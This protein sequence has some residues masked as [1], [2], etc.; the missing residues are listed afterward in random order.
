MDIKIKHKVL[1]SLILCCFTL[2]LNAQV[3]YGSASWGTYNMKINVI[4]ENNSI[5][6]HTI[7]TSEKK[8]IT[9]SP[10]LLLKLMD[11]TTISLEG[12]NLG[13]IQ[14]NDGGVVISG[15]IISDNRFISEAKFP[16]SKEQITK[17][18]KGIK[19]LR[20]NTS[21]KFHE[22]EWTTDKIGKKLYEAYLKS[23][24]NS[25]EDGF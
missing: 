8:K 7:F 17:F 22:K 24:S 10:K 3:S 23:S 6:L 12:V 9:D 1:F 21:P 5:F 2:S 4:T 19:K 20:L 15:I 14:E 16:I 11:D 13:S 25:F 18:E